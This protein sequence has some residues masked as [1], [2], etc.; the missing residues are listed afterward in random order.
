[1]SYIS[2]SGKLT[3]MEVD[4]INFDTVFS[5]TKEKLHLLSL[6]INIIKLLNDVYIRNIIIACM[7][8]FLGVVQ[9]KMYYNFLNYIK[10]YYMDPKNINSSIDDYKFSELYGLIIDSVNRIERDKIIKLLEMI[11]NECKNM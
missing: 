8:K 11:I 5:E 9:D 3:D 4:I 6:K 7:E 10:T 2:I 1:M